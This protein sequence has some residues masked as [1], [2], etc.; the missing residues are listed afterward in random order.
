MISN[1]NSRQNNRS[2]RNNKQNNRTKNQNGRNPRKG[3]GKSQP[4]KPLTASRQIDSNGPAGKIRGNVKQLYDKYNALCLEN[5]TK[6]RTTSEAHSQYAHHYYTLYAEFAAAEAALEIEREEERARKRSE[7]AE[8][9]ANIVPMIDEMS[10]EVCDKVILHEEDEEDLNGSVKDKKKPKNT[11]R[12][13]K[14]TNAKPKEDQP[15]FELDFETD[16]KVKK[17]KERKAPV[18]KRAAKIIKEE[19]IE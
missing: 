1:Q 15:R 18:R 12:A 3:S 8:N 5:R 17:L 11:K 13:S 7:A 19:L 16:E 9:Q 10:S 2:G 6:D 14:K 4:Q